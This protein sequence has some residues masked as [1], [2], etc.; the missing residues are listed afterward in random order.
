MFSICGWK[1]S[2]LTGKRFGS[3][4]VVT[5]YRDLLL[6]LSLTGGASVVQTW[7]PWWSDRFNFNFSPI[8]KSKN[9]VFTFTING[10]D[11]SANVTMSELWNRCYLS[12]KFAVGFKQ[13][14]LSW[15]ESWRG[16]GE[17]HRTSKTYF[18]FSLESSA[19]LLLG[20]LTLWVVRSS[21]AV[22]TRS[23]A[24]NQRANGWQLASANANREVISQLGGARKLT[25]S[26]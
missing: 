25:A 15:L 21:Q 4:T 18:L 23:E 5:V 20:F 12:E 14:G 10:N 2:S 3:G 1:T 26:G 11:W 24:V 17:L 7:P 19:N 8:L 13:I 6:L 22:N 9:R 16:K